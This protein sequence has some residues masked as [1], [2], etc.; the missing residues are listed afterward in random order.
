MVDAIIDE[1]LKEAFPGLKIAHLEIDGIEV[2]R[3]MK[4]L[5]KV[6]RAS[7]EEIKN[8]Y[9]GVELAEDP[10]IKA[11]RDFI[12]KFDVS[13]SK[14]KAASEALIRIVLTKGKL[15]DI[16]NVVDCMNMVSMRTGLTF[17]S[18]DKD[19]IK[20]DVVVRYSKEGERYTAIGDEEMILKA[21]EVIEADDERVLCLIRYRDCQF[22]MVDNNTKNILIHIQGVEGITEEETKAAKEELKKLVLEFAGGSVIKEDF[23]K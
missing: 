21:G 3:S 14:Q 23:L 7:R 11:Y 1:E 20:G 6:V 22:A 5:K 4:S 9:S 8:K 15:S 12:K 2:K 10:K 13:P 16:N 18:W 17:S 19:K